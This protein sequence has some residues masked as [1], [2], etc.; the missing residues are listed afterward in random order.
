[1][2]W[3][4]IIIETIIMTIAFTAIGF[5]LKDSTRQERLCPDS[6]T[7]AD[8]RSDETRWSIRFPVSFGTQL[9]Y[10]AL[11]RLV[12]LLLP[13]LGALCKYEVC[14]V[15]RHGAHGRSLPSETLPLCAVPM[16]HAHWSHSLSHWSRTLHMDY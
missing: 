12:R 8:A 15:P 4:I 11:C 6:G 16:G 1:M 13:R 3:T 7:P 14:P 10:L 5:L 2:N 9:R